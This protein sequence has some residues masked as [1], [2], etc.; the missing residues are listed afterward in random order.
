MAQSAASKGA[1]Q[2]D[3]AVRRADSER[4]SDVRPTQREAIERARELSPGSRLHI[5]REALTGLFFA[6]LHPEPKELA[7]AVL[8]V[9]HIR[10]SRL[11]LEA[12]VLSA[13]VIAGMTR[14]VQQIAALTNRIPDR[15]FAAGR[16]RYRAKAA[17]M[18]NLVAQ[19]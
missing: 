4:A 9:T 16:G 18:G 12:P 7:S 5:E 8:S 17:I 10:N 19:P 13:S 1:Q 14:V 15:R 3:Y 6:V 2:G 11:V